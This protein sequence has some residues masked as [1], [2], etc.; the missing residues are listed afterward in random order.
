MIRANTDTGVFYGTRTAL[1]ILAQDEGHDQIGKGLAKDFPKYKERGFMLDAGRKYF[2]I[3]FLEDYVKFMS[4]Y[5]MN[6]F[7]IH[8]NDNEIFGGNSR[9]NWDKYEAFRLESTKYPTLTA[10]DG[11]YTKQQFRQLQDLANL[12]G[13]TITPELDTP[14]HALSLTKVK[15]EY[16]RDSLPVDHLD[17]TRPEVVEYIKDVWSEYIDEGWFDAKELHFGGDEFDRNDKATV[18]AYLQFLN[19]MDDFFQSKGKKSRMW[20]SL[21]FFPGTTPVNS[22]IT[23]NI[24]NNGW[25]NPVTAIEQGFNIINT[26]D[27]N[28]YI[29]PKAGYYHDYLN[30]KW[31]YE[32]WDPTYFSDSI[33]LSENEPKLQGAM[34]AVWN[35]LLG[36][37]V[38]IED[39]HDRVKP[40]LPVLAEK[41]WKGQATDAT[42]DQFQ[43][44]SQA[45]GDVPG[46][47]L[48]HK[49]PSQGDTIASFA[50]EEGNGTT[51]KDTS[52]NGYDGTL[53][54]VGWTDAGKQGKGVQFTNPTDHITLGL[55]DKGF[56]W[57]VSAWV[58]LDESAIR[59]ANE[60][61]LLESS[62]GAIQLKQQGT[63][64][65][66][67]SREGYHFSFSKPIPTD[68]WVHIA[69]R[70]D[71]SGTSLFVD[72]VLQDSVPET[73]L[74]P[75]ATV[76]SASHGFTGTLDD[77]KI[78]DRSLTGKE[79]A[80]EAGSPLWTINIAAHQPAE[81]SSVE[82]DYLTPNLAFD[83]I[84][85]SSSR[86]SSMYTDNEWIRVDLGE[87]KEFDK[88]ILKWEA[89]FA[90][91]YHIQ[92]SDD[93][94]AWKDVYVTTAGSGGTEIIKFPTE[95]ARYVRM[96]GTK[97][98]GQFGYSLY[99]FEVY[100]P[101]PNDQVP[102]QVPIR[103][104]V[105]FE[106]NRIEGWE[107][108]IGKGVG[109]MSLVDDPTHT[110]LKALQ[111]Q[112]N[113][114]NNVIVDQH[115][116]DIKDGEL[117]VK[118]TPQSDTIRLGL[119][120]RYAGQ[121]SWAS[122]GFDQGTW[123]WV[124]A[125]DNYG[126]LTSNANAKL[127]KGVT[128]TVKVKFERQSI[129]LIVN[130]VT[131]FEG[132]ISQLPSADGKMGVRVFGPATGVFDDFHF[133]N[134]VPDQD[135]KVTGITLD[136][137]TMTLK[138]GE[139]AQLTATIQ[140]TNATIKDI[141]WSS[142]DNAIAS[143]TSDTYGKA[144]VTAKKEGH[145]EIIATTV[146]G[147]FQ[148][149]SVITVQ[150]SGTV[151]MLRTVLLGESTVQSGREFQVNLGLRNVTQSVYAQDLALQYDANL[152]EYVGAD[153][154]VDGV[155]V[156]Q[157]VYHVP[158][159]LRFLLVSEGADHAVTGNPDV[160]KLTFKA[161]DVAE[162][163]SW[164]IAVTKAVISNEQ[165]QEFDVAPSSLNIHVTK[166]PPAPSGDVNHDGKISIGDLAIVAAA[167]GKTDKDPDWSQVKQADLNQDGVIDIHDLAALARL[168]ITN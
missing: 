102:V 68:Q 2:P 75:L 49:V 139:T 3:E 143:V 115:S 111:V 125:Q 1:Q 38:S 147:H 50:F 149:K 65:I 31:L 131:Y 162:N 133:R 144:I 91:G 97:R 15:P 156:I 103:Y 10:K 85:S 67:F 108:V 132:P 99:E 145:A 118:V 96:L 109:K 74:L 110:S 79:I 157:S 29:V 42:Y 158:G 117:E 104:S 129:T 19:S 56:P 36:K 153:S 95:K 135:V 9:T 58:N 136:H 122:V 25:H 148:A 134:N 163:A 16:V 24:W 52:G 107:H 34:F 7:Q 22:D 94:A 57:T 4:Y 21:S 71:P 100:P 11:H 39:V 167:Y 82:V 54:G 159:E 137:N 92:V 63:G 43:Q 48:Y 105:N 119:I 64:K 88:V 151:D 12:H 5:K 30:T 59:S 155:S 83:E 90:K 55:P 84:E 6:D 18:E 161:K 116:P 112:A 141:E 138:E 27:S 40:A 47:N 98:S 76:G 166:Q 160:L 60:V 41:M 33:K 154:L 13:M 17:I 101:N 32:N 165:G 142:S 51:A 14:S 72:G 113:S 77:L 44:V 168:I 150:K 120:F 93:A 146:D 8:L 66:G 89:A 46:T 26:V 130:G 114:V 128:S 81:A 140:P 70:G 73:T 106:D 61:T 86:W 37:K 87:R 35:D 152:M 62:Y 164:T 28:L 126:A 127:A 80:Q 45:I 78:Y 20:G 124:N 53:Q 123:Y 23:V 69:L 121:D